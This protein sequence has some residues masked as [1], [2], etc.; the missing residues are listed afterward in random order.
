MSTSPTDYRGLLVIVPTRNRSDLAIRAVRST[1]S[2]S[3]GEVRILVSDNSTED[4]E[5]R[6]LREFCLSLGSRRVQY[7]RPESSLGMCQHWDWILGCILAE[8]NVNHFTFLTDRFTY[9]PSSLSSLCSLTREFSDSVISYPYDRVLD[10]STPIKLNRRP[11]SG[12]VLEFPTADILRAN[13]RMRWRALVPIL[14]NSVTPR[15]TLEHVRQHYGDFCISVAPDFCFGFR[16]L[17]VEDSILFYDKSLI[18]TSSLG[19]SNGYSFTRGVENHASRDFR[20]NIPH[21]SIAPLAPIPEINN[22]ANCSTH[23]YVLAAQRSRSGKF[24]PISFPDY[25]SALHAE[26]RFMEDSALKAYYTGLLVHHGFRPEAAMNTAIPPPPKSFINRIKQVLTSGPTRSLWWLLY[27]RMG[28]KPPNHIEFD[29]S[30]TEQ[31]IDFANRHDLPGLPGLDHIY[32]GSGV[33]PGWFTASP[34]Q[35]YGDPAS[36]RRMH[37]EHSVP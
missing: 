13:A 14:L 4:H 2:S 15:R 20:A 28:I 19:R 17:E 37:L 26:N 1:L 29:F 18:L 11:W 24:I 27:T 6:Q 34:R 12:Q 7:I 10:V 9:K 36:F 33:D 16:C 25:L 3:G 32:K 35:V 22:A 30:T 21:T 31:A 8:Y 5:V 23:E